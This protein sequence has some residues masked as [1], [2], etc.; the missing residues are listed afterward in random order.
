[1]LNFQKYLMN[2]DEMFASYKT[3]PYVTR[4]EIQWKSNETSVMKLVL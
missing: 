2:L 1:M 4:E 3:W